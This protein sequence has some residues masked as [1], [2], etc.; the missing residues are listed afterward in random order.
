MPLPACM[1]S[2]QLCCTS[3]CTANRTH[4][5]DAS[6]ALGQ[7]HPDFDGVE[8]VADQRLHQTGSSTCEQMCAQRRR[9]LG[10]FLCF[11]HGEYILDRLCAALQPEGGWE[12]RKVTELEA[13]MA[14]GLEGH[15]C[16]YYQLKIMI[17]QC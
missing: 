5:L 14:A 12:A 11:A 6:A 13:A 10:L 4:A 3:L 2:H 15:Q 16:E 1:H 8:R 7:L 9:I 17:Y